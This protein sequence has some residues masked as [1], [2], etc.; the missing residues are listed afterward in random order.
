M[1]SVE[2]AKGYIHGKEK[3]VGTVNILERGLQEQNSLSIY[4]EK[5]NIKHL[6][7]EK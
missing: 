3:L 1:P 2:K 7:S 5:N 6:C 4:G